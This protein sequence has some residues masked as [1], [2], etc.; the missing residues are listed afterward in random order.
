MIKRLSSCIREY[1]K[2]TILSPIYVTLEVV[3]DIFIPLLMGDLIDYGIDQGDMGYVLRMG[4]ALV[5]LC[6][7]S[8]LFGA[9]SGRHAAVASVGFGTNLRHDMFHHV[10]DFSL[11]IMFLL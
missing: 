4:L 2:D 3:L 9:L 10:Q 6:L 7:L 11:Y 1:K 5:A 8:L